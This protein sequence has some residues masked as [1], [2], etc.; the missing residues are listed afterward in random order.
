MT[1]KIV[2]KNLYLGITALLFAGILVIGG[3]GN[4][5]SQNNT[6]SPSVT[7]SLSNDT[8]SDSTNTTGGEATG[9]WSNSNYTTP[10]Q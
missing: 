10:V 7:L 8:A 9:N 5:F 2:S 3:I 1:N 6:D 4:A